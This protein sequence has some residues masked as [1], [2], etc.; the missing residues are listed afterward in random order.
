MLGER[1]KI[2]NGAKKTKYE[3]PC[4]NKVWGKPEMIIICGTCNKRYEGA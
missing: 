2:F 3:C 4:G 1:K